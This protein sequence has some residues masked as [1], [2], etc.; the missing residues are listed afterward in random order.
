M[1]NATLI[2]SATRLYLI[3]IKKKAFEDDDFVVKQG[4]N[5]LE[6]SCGPP[7]HITG[8]TESLERLSRADAHIFIRC[9]YLAGNSVGCGLK[10]AGN[11]ITIS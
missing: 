11:S 9:F 3:A 10:T 2:F 8:K 6:Q 7:I 1:H 4:E 5:F